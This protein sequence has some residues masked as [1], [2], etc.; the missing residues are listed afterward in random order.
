M[1][2]DSSFV[3]DS[4]R[5][6]PWSRLSEIIDAMGHASAKAQGLRKPI[7]SYEKLVC[8]PLLIINFAQLDNPNHR[9][10]L[11][12][13]NSNSPST[14]RTTRVLG[15]LK[16][17]SKHL[18]AMDETGR[19]LQISAL[20]VLD[21]YVSEVCQRHGF[22]REIFECMLE[23]EKEL[24]DGPHKLA[25]DRPSPKLQGFLRKHY[26]LCK[27]IPQANNFLIF[28]DFGLSEDSGENRADKRIYGTRILR[29]AGM[30]LDPILPYKEKKRHRDY[31]SSFQ[32]MVQRQGRTLQ[33]KELQQIVT[34][35]SVDDFYLSKETDPP[36]KEV[37]EV[38]TQETDAQETDA[39]RKE[40]PEKKVQE[41]GAQETDAQEIGTQELEAYQGLERIPPVAPAVERASYSSI[42]AS[43]LYRTTDSASQS[44]YSP[45]TGLPA[46][47]STV[48]GQKAPFLSSN[49][50]SSRRNIVKKDG[51]LL[52][53][54]KRLV[55]D[56]SVPSHFAQ[57]I[58]TYSIQRLA[59]TPL[60]DLAE[61]SRLSDSQDMTRPLEQDFYSLSRKDPASQNNT[62]PSSRNREGAML[63]DLKANVVFAATNRT[64]P[65]QY[66][67]FRR[68]SFA[69]TEEFEKS[70]RFGNS[71]RRHHHQDSSSFFSSQLGL[72]GDFSRENLIGSS[73]LMQSNRLPKIL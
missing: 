40:T 7:T 67:D 18:F 3:R 72:K 1:A 17:G 32:E 71:R 62:H 70:K 68:R 11:L 36:R 69:R 14:T 56:S 26:G 12:S 19:H 41:I 46:L 31:I 44:M 60:Q 13:A 45:V 25:Y 10:Y 15:F 24:V 20:C 61:K 54:M 52:D 22:G 16:M 27:R 64:I 8:V 58:P 39:T 5:A 53:T 28:K 66:N 37:Q 29:N 59:E 65:S 63:P 51:Q 73:M 43:S 57:G 55:H 34:D 38:G 6:Q 23:N 47:Y 42:V 21:F 49:R 30:R 33:D 9:I 35:P 4:F 2:R 48:A 50:H